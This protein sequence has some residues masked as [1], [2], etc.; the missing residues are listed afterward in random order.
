[1]AKA[2]FVPRPS[3]KPLSD[4]GNFQLHSEKRAQQRQDFDIQLKRKEAELEGHKRELEMRKKR[5][6]EE[7]VTRLRR[8]AVHKA[9]PIR[10]VIISFD[11]SHN[12]SQK[13]CSR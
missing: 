8:E 6:E 3:E 13:S 9:Q 11:H 4:V 1:M 2:P 7:E 10:L 5:E 12:L